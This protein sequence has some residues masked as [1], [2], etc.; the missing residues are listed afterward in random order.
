MAKV[1]IEDIS[2]E[3][4]L[5]RGTVSRALND[6]PDISAATK[7]KVLDACQQLNY[8]PSKAA[9]SLATGRSYVLIAVVDD[10]DQ[11]TVSAFLRGMLNKAHPA[12]YA[13]QVFELGHDPEMR[14]QRLTRLPHERA[15]G[16]MFHANLTA[17]EQAQLAAG[18]GDQPLTCYQALEGMQADAFGPDHRESGRI[19]ARH[20]LERAGKKIAY[21][22]LTDGTASAEREAG[23]CEIMASQDVPSEHCVIRVTP[24]D[25]DGFTPLHE[26]LPMLDGV[27]A[28]DDRLAASIML[29]AGRQGRQPGVNLAV[30]GQGNTSLANAL[31]PSLSSVDWGA[32]DAGERGVARVLDRIARTYTASPST[33]AVAP[34]L[35][36]R[37]STLLTR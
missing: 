37:A 31:N 17:E 1:T 34:R 26:R 6:R 12:N 11:A 8:V 30:V 5:S 32:C 36:A 3:T 25:P 15:D 27:A 9:R 14:K 10:L 35:I 23:F 18:L 20:L 19:V 4:G 16:L 7:Q 13:V 22:T 33:V 21:V 2:R 29:A 24:G 28:D